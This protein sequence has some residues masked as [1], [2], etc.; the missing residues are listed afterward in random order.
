MSKETSK[1]AHKESREMSET[2]SSSIIIHTR[3]K[4]HVVEHEHAEAAHVPRVLAVQAKQE[5]GHGAKGGHGMLLGHA[6]DEPLQL[7]HDL[8]DGVT[9]HQC[10]EQVLQR[11]RGRLLDERI[12][13]R[14]THHIGEL[15][16]VAEMTGDL[17]QRTE[18]TQTL[19]WRQGNGHLRLVVVIL[20]EIRSLGVKLLGQVLVRVRLD[21]EC[22]GV[23]VVPVVIRMMDGDK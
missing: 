11:G 15:R 13:D 16:I 17:R 14:H 6:L 5:L 21:G 3:L 2:I 20:V 10:R 4:E 9:T 1:E 19:E 12:R 8:G 23:A 22:L 18:P 7:G